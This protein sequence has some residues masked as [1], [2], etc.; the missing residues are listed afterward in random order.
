M[1]FL[2]SV[3]LGL[4]PDKDS[5]TPGLADACYCSCREKSFFSCLGMLMSFLINKKGDQGL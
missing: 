4:Q 2:E 5:I 3:Y 1:G